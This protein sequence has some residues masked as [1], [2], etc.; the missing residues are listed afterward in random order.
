MATK[1]KKPDPLSHSSAKTLQGCEQKYVHYKVL[2]T[3]KDVDAVE[4]DAFSIGKAVHYLLEV[5]RHETPKGI[6]KLL[7]HCESDPDIALDPEHRWLVAAMAIKMA[8]LHRRLGFKVLETEFGI[9]DGEKVTG[10]VDAI[11]E[12]SE[13]H[14]WIID[15]KTTKNLYLANVPA[16]CQDPQLN[17]YAAHR[18]QI[19]EK[20]NLD[21]NRFAGCRWRVVTK[22]QLKKKKDEADV[23][24][25][26]RLI[27]SAKAYDIAVPLINMDPEAALSRHLE[28]FDLAKKL[29]SPKAKPKRNYGHCLSYFRPCDYWASCFGSLYSQTKLDVVSEV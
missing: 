14:W 24:Y 16:L 17:L 25:T 6:D 18:E 5:S 7:D 20:Y 13:G 27:E 29:H 26:K 21:V 15:V 8:R 10:Y 12:D 22:P 28:L 9:G 4:G 3:P 23:D 1:A 19:A 2:K 11:M